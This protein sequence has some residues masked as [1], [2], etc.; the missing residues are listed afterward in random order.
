[1]PQR[2]K[3]DDKVAEAAEAEVAQRC[4]H[5]RLFIAKRRIELLQPI[6]FCGHRHRK[7]VDVYKYPR[8]AES[9]CAEVALALRLCNDMVVSH[10]GPPLG[11]AIEG[12]TSA[13]IHSHDESVRISTLRAERC[14]R[15]I[16]AH[17]HAGHQP[18]ANAR[19]VWGH[20]LEELVQ[21]RGCGCTLPLPGLDDGSNHEENRRVEMRLLD[22]GAKR[23]FYGKGIKP[24]PHE[25][26]L[27][28]HD[29][30]HRVSTVCGCAYNHTCRVCALAYC[31]GEAGYCSPFAPVSADHVPTGLLRASRS[32]SRR[33][34]PQPASM[35]SGRDLL[36]HEKDTP[37]QKHSGDS[38][39][40]HGSAAQQQR[41]TRRSHG[42]RPSRT[43]THPEPQQPPIRVAPSGS[44]LSLPES[45]PESSPQRSPQLLPQHYS[46]Q[47]PPPRSPQLPPQSS[48]QLH[49][50]PARVANAKMS[51]ARCAMAAQK[52]LTRG[53]RVAPLL[54]AGE[55]SAPR[56]AP[57][58][59]PST[60]MPPSPTEPCT[61]E[62]QD[63]TCAP[64]REEPPTEAVTALEPHECGS[65]LQVSWA[66]SS[67]MDSDVMDSCIEEEQMAMGGIHVN[68][69]FTHL[70][71]EQRSSVKR[72][73]IGARS[74]QHLKLMYS[75]DGVA[76]TLEQTSSA[77]SLPMRL[78]KKGAAKQSSDYGS[79]GAEANGFAE[80]SLTATSL[81][82][83][84]LT[85][86]SLA[87]S[88]LTATSLAQTSLTESWQS[89][90][91]SELSQGGGGH[92]RQRV[93]LA[94]RQ[95]RSRSRQQ[96]AQLSAH[97]LT[98]VLSH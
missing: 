83:T 70:T 42:W 94:L 82:A 85:A 88:S 84:S 69:S 56:R 36:R 54:L 24:S 23:D 15:S 49:F 20:S 71:P 72:G 79:D 59:L 10:G 33:R 95:L 86:T 1:M 22:P 19:G 8:V 12:H 76:D 55:P 47:L 73:R 87:G 7:G 90:H 57:P 21:H 53:G 75:A 25:C 58:T 74:V 96:L 37:D 4:R 64:H 28:T 89:S 41:L 52:S 80:R 48:P 32:R 35:M 81:T 31:A 92:D 43:R 30:L 38:L 45:S 78:P 2:V 34:S 40:S 27:Q 66:S 93:G 16:V 98:Q 29:R 67:Y 44:N 63:L 11:L 26:P 62:P 46:P 77:S 50:P 68:A 13:S 60:P 65:L 3:I 18:A 51:L 9:L 5:V 91:D 39:G 97:E 17:L 61:S 6:K 14:E